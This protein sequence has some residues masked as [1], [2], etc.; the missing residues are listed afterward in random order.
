MAMMLDQINSGAKFVQI[1]RE[2]KRTTPN[3]QITRFRHLQKQFELF[4]EI[5]GI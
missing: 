1:S 5:K 2:K 4:N 3:M